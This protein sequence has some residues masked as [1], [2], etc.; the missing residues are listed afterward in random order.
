MG[1]L[2][3]AFC[4][5]DRYSRLRQEVWVE[6]R[7]ERGN[8]LR[9]LLLILATAMAISVTTAAP[10]LAIPPHAHFF[11]PPGQ[12]ESHQ[13]A[14]GTGTCTSNPNGL[15]NFHEN[16]HTNPNHPLSGNITAQPLVCP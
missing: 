7:A 9:K 13:I 6:I 8:T 5:E 14:R 10:A 16:V 2:A 3:D 15:N 12:D 4:P 1:H 11:T